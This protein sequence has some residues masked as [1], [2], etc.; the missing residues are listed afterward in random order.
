MAEEEDYQKFLDFD[1]SDSRWQAYLENLYPTPNQRQIVRFKKKWYK[2]NVDPN[3]DDSYE[4]YEPPPPPPP[5]REPTPND[6]R[7][8]DEPPPVNF[9]SA[10]YTDGTRWAVMGKKSTICFAAYAMSLTIA[11]GAFA[12][13][14]PSYQALLILVSAFVLEILAKYGL[15]FKTEYMHAVLLDDVGALPIMDLT[16]LTPGIHPTL[17]TVALTPSFLTA[18]MSFAQICKNHGKLP[19]RVSDFFAPLAEPKA[20]YQIMKVRAYVEVGIGFLLLGG[21]FV[22]MAAPFSALLYWN[23]MVMRYMM[24]SWTQHTFASIDNTLSPMLN[25]IPGIKQGYAWLKGSLYGFVDPQS[26]RAGRLCTIL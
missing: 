19:A 16:L 20:R 8:G 6:G 2:K 22:A 12:L 25:M 23:F 3:F 18:L 13:V 15:K 26:K 21:I 1:W 10:S 9:P 4:P 14:F 7:M 11:T 17:R 5:P 24:S